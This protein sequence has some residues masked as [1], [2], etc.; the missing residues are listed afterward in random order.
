MAPIPLTAAVCGFQLIRDPV[1]QSR[2][3][4]VTGFLPTSSTMMFGGIMHHQPKHLRG[5]F[6]PDMIEDR[7]PGPDS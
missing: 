2:R 7:A 5:L 4:D 3:V 6:E 1:R